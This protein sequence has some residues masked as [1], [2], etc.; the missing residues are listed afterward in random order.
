MKRRASAT[1]RAAHSAPRSSQRSRKGHR[2]ALPRAIRATQGHRRADAVLPPLWH[3]RKLQAAAAGGRACST[4]APSGA[5]APCVDAFRVWSGPRTDG[6]ALWL[7]FQ[8]D[9]TRRRPNPKRGTMLSQ[10]TP[11]Q[12]LRRRRSVGWTNT[13]PWRRS[14]SL[15]SPPKPVRCHTPHLDILSGARELERA[16]PVGVVAAGLQDGLF[17]ARARRGRR[18]AGLALAL[19][20]WLRGH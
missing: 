18:L 3:L 12:N 16:E 17:Q 1:A 20:L 9:V 10:E 8:S 7:K 19:G 14:L 11:R 4:A 6:T 2:H 15:P 5:S 13:P